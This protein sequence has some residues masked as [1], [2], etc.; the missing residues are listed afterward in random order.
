MR[1]F[2]YHLWVLLLFTILLIAVEFQADRFDSGELPRTSIVLDALAHFDVESV[3]EMMAVFTHIERSQ[4]RLQALV[5]AFQQKQ[6]H[7]S[8]MMNDE[9]SETDESILVSQQVSKDLARNLKNTEDS[10]AKQLAAIR[11][12]IVTMPKL[13]QAQQAFPIMVARMTERYPKQVDLIT[14][15]ANH[16][17]Q[18]QLFPDKVLRQ[19]IM[20][21]LPQ[22]RAAGLDDLADL[23]RLIVSYRTRVVDAID[24]AEHSGTTR[25]I[26][27]V[28]ENFEQHY[29][30]E[31][32]IHAVSKRILGVMVGILLLYLM[33]LLLGSHRKNLHLKRILDEKT[34]LQEDNRLLLAAM[35]RAPNGILVCNRDGKILYANE[36]LAKMHGEDDSSALLGRYAAELRGGQPHDLFYQDIIACT[37]SG[38][39]WHGDYTLET[40]E[41]RVTIVSRTMSAIVL[42]GHS[43]LVGIDRDVTQERAQAAKLE[44]IQR[45]ESLGVLAGGIAHDFNNIL[46][47]IRGNAMLAKKNSSEAS[48]THLQRIEE[49]TQ[50]AA[51]LC[52]QMLAYAGKGEFVVEALDLSDLVAD[53]SQLIAVSID[54]NIELRVQLTQELPPVKG[55]PAQLQ[56]IVLNLITNANEAIN[57]QSSWSSG[58][59]TIT[60]SERNVD[61]AILSHA[62]GGAEIKAGTFVALEVTDNGCGIDDATKQRMFEPFFTTK[63][64]GRGLGMSAILGIVQ[65]HHGALLLESE[66]GEGTRFC[67][68]LPPTD[69]AIPPKEDAINLQENSPLSGMVLIIDDEEVIREMAEEVLE[70]VGLRTLSAENGERGIELFRHHQSEIDAV[71]LDMTMPVMDGEACFKALRAIQDD[72]PVVVASGYAE[73]DVIQAFGE[74]ALAG[75]L[76]KPFDPERLQQTMQKIVIAGHRL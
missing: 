52:Q 6:Q 16:L 54:K 47:A 27:L 22:L 23:S 24:N 59:I 19:Q 44:A 72:L 11:M 32:H 8:T 76:Q 68:L 4:Q 17:T 49:G 13:T 7:L 15:F 41:E 12:F 75:F 43:Y 37:D 40:E 48:A 31:A 18:W 5:E 63:F 1:R 30:N 39:S 61:D 58:V 35:R 2:K 55:D 38:D 9:V 34:V 56:Q 70:E 26:S 21:Q 25:N 10:V 33:L 28:R 3:Q 74:G 69:E 46:T 64:T 45:L 42:D 36:R 20:H 65:S 51:G 14:M 73:R 60:T 62:V 66:P 67:L 29:A 53:V 71:L 57:G 50:K